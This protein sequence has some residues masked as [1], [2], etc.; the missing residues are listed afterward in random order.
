MSKK[1]NSPM[2]NSSTIKM[3][4]M[5]AMILS[6]IFGAALVGISFCHKTASE[7]YV[8]GQDAPPQIRGRIYDD[9]RQIQR[10]EKEKK[11]FADQIKI[12][13]EIVKMPHHDSVSHF[14]SNVATPEQVSLVKRLVDH[15]SNSGMAFV[16]GLMD[17]H[18]EKVE[19]SLEHGTCEANKMCLTKDNTYIVHY[20][21][22]EKE[23]VITKE[24]EA[25]RFPIVCDINLFGGDPVPGTSKKCVFECEKKSK[26]VIRSSSCP[27]VA[28][29]EDSR[30]WALIPSCGMSPASGPEVILQEAVSTFCASS[31][32]R[33]GLDAWLDCEYREPF[34]RAVGAPDNWDGVPTS[35]HWIDKA[36]VTF[37]AG[38]AT[39]MKH[40]MMVTNLIRSVHFFSA[41]PIVVYVVG[42]PELSKDWNPKVFPRLIVIHADSIST[43]NNGQEGI[44]FNFNKFRS[45][46]L[47]IRVGLQVD[48]DMVVGQNCDRLFDATEKHSNADYPYPI[49]PVHWMSRYKEEGKVIDG[50]GVYAL[51]YPKEW[52][53]RIR[54]S[55][56]HPTWTY[57]AL[58]FIADAL[59]AKLDYEIWAKEPRVVKALGPAPPQN[60]SVYMSEDEDLLNI[61]L[62]R[63]KA[64]KQWCKWDVEPDIFDKYLRQETANQETMKDSKWYPEGVPLV[65]VTMHNTKHTEV[66]DTMLGRLAREGFPEAY[67]FF[68]DKYYSSPDALVQDHQELFDAGKIPCILV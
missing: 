37:F 49:M 29:N 31:K 64:L 13:G 56:C 54:W 39:G 53:P 19:C 33:P 40:S 45:M 8:V 17:T 25:S 27:S 34:A 41:H 66:I 35:E 6:T 22:P 5:V 3:L 65:I 61:L 57:H 15:L 51:D 26:P 24:L 47:R 23:K 18:P 21:L 16:K 38:P 32:F 59:L 67:L 20:G 58:P 30:T 43:M 42:T 46:L 62:W 63:H 7:V 12:D 44:S 68:K 1:K 48:A 9:D 2:V 4:L 60:P 28:G 36:W 14:I 50:F 11:E 10:H 52:P 55:H